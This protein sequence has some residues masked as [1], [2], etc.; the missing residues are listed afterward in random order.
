MQN[1]I[2][3]DGDH[4]KAESRH[5]LVYNSTMLETTLIPKRGGAGGYTPSATDTPGGIL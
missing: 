1:D 2:K 3:A 5:S 4:R